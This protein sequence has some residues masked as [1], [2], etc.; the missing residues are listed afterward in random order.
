[1]SSIVGILLA[2][3][4]ARRFGAHKLMRPLADGTPVGVAAASA[5]VRAVPD[6]IAVVRPD[7]H[8][9]V[10]ALSAVGLK[11]VENP[12]ADQGMGTSLAAGVSSAAGAD[13]WLI[14]LADMPW[15]HTETIGMLAERLSH[16]ASMVAPLYQG[17]RG[18]PAGFSCRWGSDL[19][20]L[21][22]DQGA[23]ELFARYA[24][25]AELLDTEDA[26]VVLDVDR[27]D[28]LVRQPLN[29]AF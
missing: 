25:E 21:S 5:L 28:D 7:D 18:H 2:A 22:G 12:F 17:G 10:D 11:I 14:A 9:L 16:G 24:S 29:P 13:G 1:M 27:P 26:G 23:R 19:R 20:A 15:V 3:G 4:S 6:C 8:P